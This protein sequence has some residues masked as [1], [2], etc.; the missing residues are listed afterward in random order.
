VIRQWINSNARSLQ[1]QAY[2]MQLAAVESQKAS[3]LTEERRAQHTHNIQGVA[4]T[5]QQV[6]GCAGT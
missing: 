5:R 6:A 1:Q 3:Q 4:S 2:V